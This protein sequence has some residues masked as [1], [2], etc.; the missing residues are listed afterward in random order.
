MRLFIALELP[1]EVQ[2]ATALLQQQ[3]RRN[4]TYP[5]KWVVPENFH[6]TLR[7]LGEVADEQVP[8]LLDAMEVIQQAAAPVA[9]EHLHL[10]NGGAF[11]NLRRPQTIWVG[12]GGKVEALSHIHQ[13]VEP[14]IAPLGFVPETRPFRA[15]LTI[16]RTQRGAHSSQQAA[17]G[18]AIEALPRPAPVRWTVGIPMLFQSTLTRGG[19]IYTKVHYAPDR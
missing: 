3:L 4:G 13:A 15:H 8:A 10:T 9:Q 7:F 1:P 19:A 12:I 17:L 16:G 6:I 5:V 18:R 14:A 2:A 11:P